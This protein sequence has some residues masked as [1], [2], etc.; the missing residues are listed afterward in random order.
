[1]EVLQ[2]GEHTR[3]HPYAG[4]PF[5]S[6]KEDIV[7]FFQAEGCSRAISRHLL[8]LHSEVM[9]APLAK[10]DVGFESVDDSEAA[11]GFAQEHHGVEVH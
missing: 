1:V 5:S 9:G 11:T 8:C 10:A 2:E 3:L 7:S 6:T 4:L